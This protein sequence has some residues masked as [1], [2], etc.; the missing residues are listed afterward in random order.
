VANADNQT[1][2]FSLD[3]D[4]NIGTG[5]FAVPDPEN[6]EFGAAKAVVVPRI[7]YQECVMRGEFT[8]AFKWIPGPQAYIEC[9]V[10]GERCVKDCGHDYCLCVRG[11]CI[12]P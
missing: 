9:P 10:V 7:T 6:P 1:K 12:S 2:P 4:Q 11:R 3:T 5:V 8:M